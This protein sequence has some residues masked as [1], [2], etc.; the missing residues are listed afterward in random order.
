MPKNVFLHSGNISSSLHVIPYDPFNDEPLDRE[1][2]VLNTWD[3]QQ[4]LVNPHEPIYLSW[5]FGFDLDFEEELK[6]DGVL[7]TIWIHQDD[8]SFNIYTYVGTSVT[9]GPCIFLTS[10]YSHSKL[11]DMLSTR[12]K[13]S[14]LWRQVFTL[15]SLVLI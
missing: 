2:D 10:P 1:E 14:M 8:P 15:L 12:T 7:K 5:L 9:A 11:R 13:F 6:E 3:K 4:E